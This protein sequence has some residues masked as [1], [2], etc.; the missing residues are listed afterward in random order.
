MEKIPKLTSK[1]SLNAVQIKEVHDLLD[2]WFDPY[3]L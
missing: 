3:N 1:A 2:A